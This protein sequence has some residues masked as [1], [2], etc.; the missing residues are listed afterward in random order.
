MPVVEA[1]GRGTIVC[2]GASQVERARAIASLAGLH[3]VVIATDAPRDV[4]HG[5]FPGVEVDSDARHALST[6]PATV[7]L[8]M[9]E[10]EFLDDAEVLERARERGIRILCTE[11]WPLSIETARACAEAPSSGVPAFV[12]EFRATRACADLMD[13]V[14]DLGAVR[15]VVVTGRNARGEGSLA[16]RLFDAMTLVHGLL[17]L[18]ET[19]DAAHVPAVA[20]TVGGAV[21]AATPEAMRNLHGDLTA[22]VRYSARRCAAV[23]VSNTAGP[24][25]RGV[26]VIA[27]RGSVRATEQGMERFDPSGAMLDSSGPRA[28]ERDAGL[29]A[30]ARAVERAL[31]PRIPAP[32]PSDAAEVLAMCHAALLSA[33][34]SQA[35]P[36]ATLLRMATGA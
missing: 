25:F 11:P 24:W 6:A 13:A 7:A 17:G 20:G 23:A 33:R 34:T 1:K 8:W 2:C 12:P 10:P 19:I 27:E 35:E 9:A 36:P 22:N 3:P 26:T 31:D 4:V 14:S 32:P 5:V 29:A 18:A 30:V 28:V 15:S 21:G 16:A